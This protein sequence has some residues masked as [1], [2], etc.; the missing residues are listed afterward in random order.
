MVVSGLGIRWDWEA[1]LVLGNSQQCKR[2][3]TID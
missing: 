1:F 3:L 2:V